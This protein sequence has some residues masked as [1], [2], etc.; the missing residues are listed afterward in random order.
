MTNKRVRLSI[1]YFLM[2]FVALPV[3]AKATPLVT[4]ISPKPGTWANPQPLVLNVLSDVEVYYSLNGS[5]PLQFGFAYDE[6]VI[7]DK[8]GE[9]SVQISTISKTSSEKY[10]I[11]YNVLEKEQPD[12]IEKKEAQSFITVNSIKGI[13]I[14][15]KYEYELGESGRRYSGRILKFDQAVTISRFVPLIVY[16]NDDA[17]RYVLKTGDSDAFCGL[18][19]NQFDVMY[20]Q[21]NYIFFKNGGPVIYSINGGDVL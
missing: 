3:W 10:S 8:T 14:P 7:I 16:V 9:V 15:E 2:M 21:W 12:F 13:D 17:Y 11:T 19:A 20:D 18:S 1:I 4:V 6:P 5:D